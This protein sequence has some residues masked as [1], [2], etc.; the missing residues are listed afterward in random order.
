MG[1]SP[2]EDFRILLGKS[3]QDVHELGGFWYLLDQLETLN[4][5][6]GSD[7]LDG[8]VLERAERA[9]T[10]ALASPRFEPTRGAAPTG[11]GLRATRARLTELRNRIVTLRKEGTAGEAEWPAR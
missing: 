9:L 10:S 3:V 2:E 6:L 8:G 4:D 11:E 7:Q 5:A 1:P